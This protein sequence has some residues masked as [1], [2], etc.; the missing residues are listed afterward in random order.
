MRL[1]VFDFT[2]S[3]VLRLLR[4]VHGLLF[5][6]DDFPGSSR[7]A[8]RTRVHSRSISEDPKSVTLPIFFPLPNSERWTATYGDGTNGSVCRF[9]GPPSSP[10]WSP[11]TTHIPTSHI[12]AKL[13]AHPHR[14]RSSRGDDNCSDC[15]AATAAAT[16]TT[17]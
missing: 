5:I 14:F 1:Q 16:T 11:A 6:P 15:G 10:R 8:T 4:T 9:G 17:S 7:Y 3:P 2:C 12:F 13:S